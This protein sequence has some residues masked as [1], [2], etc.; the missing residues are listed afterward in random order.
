MHSCI[1]LSPHLYMIIL[2]LRTP[3]IP[4]ISWLGINGAPCC[5]R[6]SLHTAGAGTAFAQNRRGGRRAGT[7]MILGDS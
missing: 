6:G 3:N 1:S 2:C 5:A 4:P 7:L